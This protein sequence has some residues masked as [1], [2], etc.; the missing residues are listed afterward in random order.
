MTDCNKNKLEIGDLVAY[1]R[2]GYKELSVGKVVRFTPKS[3]IVTE[4]DGNYE[5]SRF[6]YQVAKLFNQNI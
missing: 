3:I 2:V 6:P 5:Q 1:C 4:I